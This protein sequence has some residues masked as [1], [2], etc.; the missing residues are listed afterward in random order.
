MEK[1][2]IENVEALTD[3]DEA[4]WLE[5]VALL[6]MA[7]TQQLLNHEEQR[8]IVI[9]DEY[10]EFLREDHA[11]REASRNAERRAKRQRAA[12]LADSIHQWNELYRLTESKYMVEI[13]EQTQNQCASINTWLLSAG[14]PM[15]SMDPAYQTPIILDL[16]ANKS[17]IPAIQA[18]QDHTY[19]PKIFQ[20]G[21]THVLDVIG[22]G[23]VGGLRN[24][25]QPAIQNKPALLSASNYLDAW[26]ETIITVNA[27]EAI[28]YE[29][30]RA[31]NQ[32]QTSNILETLPGLR[33]IAVF[34][35]VSNLYVAPNYQFL[36]NR[37]IRPQQI[38]MSTNL[39]QQIQIGMMHEDAI[40]WDALDVILDEII[41]NDQTSTP[42]SQIG[43]SAINYANLTNNSRIEVNLVESDQ[44]DILVANYL[45]A[46]PDSVITVSAT[47]AIIYESTGVINKLPTSK[48]LEASPGLKTIAVFSQIG[49]I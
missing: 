5:A 38:P 9:I 39:D 24:V 23:H 47:E 25:L 44:K 37:P 22:I 36:Y 21:T 17:L 34:H 27:K 26:P 32:L 33:I 35:Q 10:Y 43:Q 11:R 48:I 42:V 41:W 46:L 45:D 2:Y 19:F 8:A 16:G 40:E 30:C 7:H 4:D 18:Y 49:N 1:E 6:E 13:E 3:L 12:F 15:F 28:I 20:L 14:N 29:S 31:N